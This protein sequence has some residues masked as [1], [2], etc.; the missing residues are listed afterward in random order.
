MFPQQCFAH[1]QDIH[2]SIKARNTHL[3]MFFS[4]FPS[5]EQF[6]K[7]DGLYLM[8]V[9]FLNLATEIGTS[10]PKSSL[11]VVSVSYSIHNFYAALYTS[12]TAFCVRCV[13][14]S[15]PFRM[16]VHQN[17]TFYNSSLWQQAISLVI[18]TDTRV[19][20]ICVFR[21]ERRVAG[22]PWRWQS[23]IRR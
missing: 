19:S 22:P 18:L 11:C 1:S 12:F 4:F 17:D 6:L 14:H 10:P 7:D 16:L 20:V 3:K 5:P 9:S 8:N 21:S 13:V 2:A 23:G 15:E